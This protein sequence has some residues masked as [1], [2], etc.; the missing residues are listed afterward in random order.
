MRIL[1]RH[2]E[3]M[4]TFFEAIHRENPD[5][6]WSNRKGVMLWGDW[7]SMPEKGDQGRSI[8]LDSVFSATPL[9]LFATAFFCRDADILGRVARIL[10][11]DDD[12][13]C[14]ENL[15]ADI[16]AAFVARFMDAGGRLE[17]DTQTAYALAICFNLIPEDMREAAGRHLVAAVEQHNWHLSTG[18]TGTELLLPALADTGHLDVAY[19]L[20]MN[21]TYPSWGY[22][23]DNGATTIWER[24]DGWT[25][26]RGFQDERM[27]SFNHYAFGSVGA[28]MFSDVAGIGQAKDESGFAHVVLRPRPGG[29]IDWAKASLDSIRGRIECSWSKNSDGFNLDATIPAN[30]RATIYIPAAA[31]RV[32]EG[33]RP[34]KEAEGVTSVLRDGDTLV[35]ETGSGRYSFNAPA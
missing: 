35:V 5:L 18:F 25:Q 17:G 9:D 1:E 12:A 33:G 23:I 32:T 20:L 7:L 10:G 29:D 31:G 22:S 26:D 14:Y 4:T 24:W 19:R 2:Y 27:N 6:I 8:V 21:R 11:R 13:K 15:A 34:V 3:A 30:S 16:R 28:W